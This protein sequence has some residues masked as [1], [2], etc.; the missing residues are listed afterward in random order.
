MPIKF[1][2]KVLQIRTSE[3][4]IEKLDFCCNK[5]GRTKAD[6]IRL[7]VEKVYQELKK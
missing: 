2:L 1:K 3:E 7:G 6:V 4:F 5:T